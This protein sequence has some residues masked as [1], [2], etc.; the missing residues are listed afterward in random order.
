MGD[1]SIKENTAEDFIAFM[2]QRHGIL[3]AKPKFDLEGTD[4]FAMLK[5]SSGKSTIFK[6]CRIQCKYRALSEETKKNDVSIP[7]AHINN[8]YIVFL[9]VENGDI[10]QN[11]LY[12]FFWNDITGAGSPWKPSTSKGENIFRL[13]LHLN[14]FKKRLSEYLFDKKKADK[15]KKK[16]EASSQVIRNTEGD[17]NLLLPTCNIEIKRH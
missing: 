13:Y 2:L 8:D 11:H 14:T 7:E 16:I 15:I 1:T 4:L 6:Y 17:L 5:T 10:T 12:C 9:Y 3:I